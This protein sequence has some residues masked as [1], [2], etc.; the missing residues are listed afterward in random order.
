MLFLS[1]LES[2]RWIKLAHKKGAQS[3]R[4]FVFWK[5]LH[6]HPHKTALHPGSSLA[7]FLQPVMEVSTHPHAGCVLCPP[8]LLLSCFQ[9]VHPPGG[10]TGHS[11]A[12]TRGAARQRCEI[13]TAAVLIKN[14]L[15]E[16]L[17]VLCWDDQTSQRYF[18]FSGRPMAAATA[19][20]PSVTCA[21]Q[22][23]VS[24]ISPYLLNCLYETDECFQVLCCAS[25]TMYL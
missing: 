5:H 25:I 9:P 13:T 14:L 6:T 16:S 15:S 11:A 3:S 24:T 4:H 1:P 7:A 22:A 23:K 8:L 20:T 19:L 2:P 17:A 21:S 10:K 12:V 18:T